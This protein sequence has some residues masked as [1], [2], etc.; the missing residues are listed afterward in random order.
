VDFQWVRKQFANINMKD[1]RLQ[2]RVTAIATACAKNPQASLPDRFAEWAGLKAAYRFFDNPKATHQVIQEQHYKNVL[3][4]AEITEGTVLFI[5]DGS[6]LLFNTH[7]WTQGLG[8]T[9]DGD[10]N[11]LMFHSCLVAKYHDSKEPEVLGLGYQEAWVRPER[12]RKESGEKESAVWLRTLGKM[13]MPRPGWITVG[14]RGNDIYEFLH[15]ADQQKWK[16]VVRARHDRKVLVKGEPKR[17]FPW[18]R[19]QTAKCKTPLYLRA[20]GREFAGEVTLELTWAAAEVLPPGKQEEKNVTAVTYLRVWCPERPQIEWLLITN[21]PITDEEEARKVVEIYRRRWLI[22]D[23]HKALK[24]GCR[25][26]ENQFKQADRILAL[27]GVVGVIATKLLALRE[28]CRLNPFKLADEAIPKEWILLVEKYL[29]TKIK[30]AR[31]F[32]RCIAQMGGFIG[33]KSD[34]EPGWQTLWKGYRKFSDM[35]LGI[36]VLREVVGNA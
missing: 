24:T 23:Y 11:G 9:A 30:T 2:H 19:G 25:V 7:K 13:G 20:N 18:I 36:S 10:G 17:L 27:L 35:L 4:E 32:W 1:R 29:K 31:D 15:G 26:E 6:E 28:T 34:G 8:P 16:F 5:Q 12:K 21:L 33:R 22:E 3:R 14:D